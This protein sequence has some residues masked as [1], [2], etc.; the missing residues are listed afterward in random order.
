MD[1]NNL[2]LDLAL[3]LM[4]RKNKL[5]SG[6]YLSL[7]F[8]LLGLP[9]DIVRL[10]HWAEEDSL[11]VIQSKDILVFKPTKKGKLRASNISLDCLMED[12]K[13]DPIKRIK[14]KK[15]L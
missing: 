6:Y 9:V 5:R 13:L 2:Y 1:I 11:V 14:L 3:L 7:Y 12:L 8:D 10:L 15:S 4:T